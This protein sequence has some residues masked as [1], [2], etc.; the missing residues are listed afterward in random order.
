MNS[1]EDRLR[2]ATLAAAD[3]VAD[4]S[5]APLRLPAHPAPRRLPGVRLAVPRLMASVATAAAVVAVIA[6][7]VVARD[8]AANHRS[9][10]GGGPGGP[11]AITAQVPPF[12]VAVTATST[13]PAAPEYSDAVIA[14]TGTGK[15]LATVHPPAPYNSFLAVSA[16]AD[17]RT[18]VLAAQKLPRPSQGIIQPTGPIRLYLL[19]L[20]PGRRLATKLTPLPIPVVRGTFGPIELALS[21]SGTRLAVIKE[22]S[23]FAELSQLRVYNLANG[24]TRVWSL[25]YH[26][27]TASPGINSP[28]WDGG[29]RFLSTLVYTNTP[30]S[31]AAG[32]VQ[33]LDTTRAGGNILATSKT[34]F[35][36]AAIHRQAGWD[37]IFI[38]PD[39]SRMILTGMAGKRLKT[40]VSSLDTPLAYE[41][42]TP[43]GR[44]LS[45]LTGRP[46][47]DFL[48][49]WVGPRAKLVIFGQPGPHHTVTAVIYSR[50]KRVPLRLPAHTRE[51]SW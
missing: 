6:T 25:S 43:S 15:I 8:V 39:G 48:P 36:T 49:W 11:G 27:R 20:H 16:A 1:V 4:Q 38:A 3:T 44:I 37:N 24:Q 26:V 31:C 2:A 32:C 22:P 10:A 9:P 19:R 33:L 13:H 46:G 51:A 42:A 47:T 28:T 17:D 35:S 40:G 50:H 12:F 14:R 34:I 45:H 18:F 7:V 5:Q 23:G 41:I 21:P 29:S 30:K